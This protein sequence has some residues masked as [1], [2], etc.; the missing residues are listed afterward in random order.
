MLVVAGGHGRVAQAIAGALSVL[1]GRKRYAPAK[2][3]E[4]AYAAAL[5]Y[6]ASLGIGAPA[7]RMDALAGATDLVLVPTFD[8]R[9]IEQLMSLVRG[10][11]AAGVE[12]I[13][14][15]SLAG[16][17]VR[18]PVTLLRW[19]GLVEREA[20]GTGL[21]CTVLRCGPFMQAIPMFLR[22]DARG[23]A[24]V[25]PFRDTAFPWTDAEDAGEILA[26][27]VRRREGKSLTCQ[28][29]GTEEANFETVARLLGQALGEPV[30]YVDVCLPE[31]QGMLER[32]GFPPQRVRAVT[33]YWD[34]LVSG[35]VRASC[36]ELGRGL[37]G[38]PPHTLA[39]YLERYAATQL[40]PA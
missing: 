40:A 7:D 33:E 2:A 30:A 9:A 1:P 5:G 8:P 6:E 16:A 31:A 4:E 25:G 3:G 35:V 17:D 10:A 24:L 14:L 12:R 21:P 22:R 23:A 29:C 13:H 15:L 18:S 11:P 32:S 36:C 27:I 39:R 28:L 19:I 37:L 26:G 38:R 20:G 34:Y